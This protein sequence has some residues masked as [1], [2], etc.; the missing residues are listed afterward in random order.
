MGGRVCLET[1]IANLKARWSLS[2][3]R[4][5][6]ADLRQ[7]LIRAQV[8]TFNVQRDDPERCRPIKIISGFPAED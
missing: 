6:E 1:T 3:G 7:R 5:P 8:R 2:A 4:R